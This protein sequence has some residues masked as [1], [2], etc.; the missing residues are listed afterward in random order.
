MQRLV[1]YPLL[2]D[3]I[4]RYTAE[5]SDEFQ[6]Y[7]AASAGAK[8][9]LS[10]VNTAKRDAENR[11]YLQDIHRKIEMPTTS[12]PY[13]EVIRRFDIMQ[14]RY[15]YDGDVT[16]RHSRGKTD[17]HLV[18]LDYL[19]LLLTRGQDGKYHMRTQ[20]TSAV[21]LL[22]LPSVTVE[23]KQGDKRALVIFYERDLRTFELQAQSVTE[24]KT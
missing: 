11:R 18:L 15:V 17:M 5:S 8:K 16:W 13:D 22:W 20:D 3:T 4:L 1:K 2:L 7:S 6:Q 9:L 12:R 19:L 14:Y 21:P 24:K 10:A 23:E